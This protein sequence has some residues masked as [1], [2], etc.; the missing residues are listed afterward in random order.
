[1]P[2][3]RQPL[4]SEARP[5]LVAEWDAVLNDGVPHGVTLGSARRVWWCCRDWGRRW[6]ASTSNRVY[7]QSG[8]PHCALEASRKP[9]PGRSVLEWDPLL[10]TEWHPTPNGELGPGDVAVGSSR[11][12]WWR[13]PECKH[14]WQARVDGRA[15]RRGR[16]PI[17]S[18]MKR[19]GRR[20]AR[21]PAAPPPQ[22][23]DPGPERPGR[24]LHGQRRSALAS[25]DRRDVRRCSRAGGPLCSDRITLGSQPSC[26]VCWGDM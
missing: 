25:L 23:D 14:E 22:R 16:C 5:D 24:G 8:C 2:Y 20:W 19:R 15:R 18:Q 26:E 17:C 12:V 7:R 3:N 11:V 13:C 6:Q 21:G 1:M 4:L 9:N 10:A